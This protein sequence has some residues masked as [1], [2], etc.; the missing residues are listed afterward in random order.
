MVRY[1]EL[2]A[3][4]RVSFEAEPGA[5]VGLLGPNGAGKT[6]VIRALTTVIEPASGWATVAG[7]AISEPLAVRHRIGVLPESS[8]YPGSRSAWEYLRFHGRLFGLDRQEAGRRA[9]RLLGE[10][11]LGERAGSRIGTFS[12]G[13]RQRL[14]IARALINEPTVLFLDEPT[15]GLDP[16]GKEDIL[17]HVR[18]AARERGATVLVSSHLLDEVERVCDRVVI[19][20]LGKVAASGTVGDVVRQAGVAGEVR[21]LV[22]TTQQAAA[23]AALDG[24]AGVRGVQATDRGELLVG[25]AAPLGDDNAILRSLVNAQVAVRGFEVAGGRLGDA[26]FALTGAERSSVEANDAA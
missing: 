11:G 21:V 20:H 23:T 26:F 3:V 22:E 10:L 12:R 7:A 9:T 17:A 8:G 15:L 5:V 4:D 6:S 18:S 14:G 24:V 25:L 1:G 2:T 16:A 13:M 19:M